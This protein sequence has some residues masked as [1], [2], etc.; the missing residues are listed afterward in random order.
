MDMRSALVGLEPTVQIGQRRVKMAVSRERKVVETR[1]QDWRVQEGRISG[2]GG[3]FQS[4]RT[5]GW[6]DINLKRV[7]DG[8][9]RVGT[10]VS[11]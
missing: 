8:R 10:F 7:R 4:S 2:D 3:C 11:S 6:R 9:G 1:G 5:F